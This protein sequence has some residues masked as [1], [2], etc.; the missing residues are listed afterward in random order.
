MRRG[1]A[2]GLAFDDGSLKIACLDPITVCINTV[3]ADVFNKFMETKIRALPIISQ[4]KQVLD[5]SFP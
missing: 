1:L 4:D 2:Q 5:C 3:K